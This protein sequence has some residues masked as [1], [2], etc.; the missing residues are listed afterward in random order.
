MSRLR[1]SSPGRLPESPDKEPALVGVL[2][3]RSGDP[4]RLQG[5]V[6]GVHWAHRNG[7]WIAMVTWFRGRDTVIRCRALTVIPESPYSQGKENGR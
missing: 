6:R 4:A 3:R 5:R 1:T 2:V 7:C